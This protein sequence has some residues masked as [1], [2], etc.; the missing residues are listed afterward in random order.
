MARER[1]MEPTTH[2]GTTV[3]GGKH[4]TTTPP[5]KHTF[6]IDINPLDF[7]NVH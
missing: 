5:I 4:F 7:R 1:W 6:N 3:L 2:C